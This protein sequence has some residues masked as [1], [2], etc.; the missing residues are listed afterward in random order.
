MVPSVKNSIG[1]GNAN[2]EEKVKESI[3][4]SDQSSVSDRR[5]NLGEKEGRTLNGRKEKE[6]QQ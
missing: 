2:V 6:A 5:G 4:L 3:K 1:G